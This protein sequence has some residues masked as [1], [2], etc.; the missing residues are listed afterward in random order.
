VTH[1]LVQEQGVSGQ[2]VGAQQ[3]SQ[4][5]DGALEQVDVHALV[6]AELGGHPRLRLFKL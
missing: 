2:V 3:A 6:K 4:D 5:A 1:G